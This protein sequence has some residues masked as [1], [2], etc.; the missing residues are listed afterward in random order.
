MRGVFQ[1]LISQFL[2]LVEAQLHWR[3]A[4]EDGHEHRELLGGGLN[5][6]TQLPMVVNGPSVT[7]T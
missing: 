3:V 7:V 1:R 2:Y 6:E 4:T 5:V